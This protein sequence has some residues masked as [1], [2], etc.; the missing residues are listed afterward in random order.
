MKKLVLVS[1]LFLL[2]AASCDKQSIDLPISEEI[3][4]GHNETVRKR[5]SQSIKVHD[6]NVNDISLR[7]VAVVQEVVKFSF[8]QQELLDSLCVLTDTTHDAAIKRT[9]KFNYRPTENKIIA[10]MYDFEIGSFE[11]EFVYDASNKV[12]RITNQL[13]GRENGIYYIYEQNKLT[14]KKYTFGRVA[15]AGNFV[16]DQFL[17]LIQYEL[18]NQVE[19]AIQISLDYN[20]SMPIDQQFDIRFS[21]KEIS[22][23]YEGGVNILKLMGLN[24]GIGNRHFVKRRTERFLDTQKLRNTYDYFYKFDDFSRLEERRI[25]INDSLEVKYQYQY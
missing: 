25:L 4:F 12:L 21:S 1:F 17:D 5:I 9:A 7:S 19:G 16:Y 15:I 22:F 11:M 23:L 13:Y 24:D 20:L 14:N 18:H 6:D 8:N 2:F 3:D 10:Q